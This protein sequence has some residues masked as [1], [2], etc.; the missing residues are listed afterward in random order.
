MT[1]LCTIITAGTVF[2]EAEAVEEPAEPST[3]QTEKPAGSPHPAQPPKQAVQAKKK[4]KLQNSY[5]G[6]LSFSGEFGGGYEYNLNMLDLSFWATCSIPHIVFD[7]YGFLDFSYLELTCGTF[8]GFMTFAETVD[9]GLEI[10][11]ASSEYKSTGL[12]FGILGK[13]PIVLNSEIS[14]FPL[15]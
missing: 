3:V 10:I 5:G 1:L 15:A 12:S 11:S 2:A 13:L 9:T 8:T 6:G 14:I 7:V 4:R